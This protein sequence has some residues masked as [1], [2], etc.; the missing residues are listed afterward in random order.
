MAACGVAMA[1]LTAMAVFDIEIGGTLFASD[2]VESRAVA[3]VIT[4]L[5]VAVAALFGIFVLLES[6]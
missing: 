4:V 1:T 6:D 3:A 5:Q 2:A